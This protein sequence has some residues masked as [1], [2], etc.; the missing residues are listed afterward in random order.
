MVLPAEDFPL[1]PGDV[2]VGEIGGVPVYVGL[3]ELCAWEHPDFVV[4]VEPGGAEGLSLA[5]G[6]GLHF[7]AGHPRATAVSGR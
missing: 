6:P 1:G 3:R 7:V 4:D 2:Q 5:P